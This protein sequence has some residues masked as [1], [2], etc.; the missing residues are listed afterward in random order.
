MLNVGRRRRPTN[1]RYVI[2]GEARQR[3]GKGIQEPQSSVLWL[4]DPL[5]LAFAEARASAPARPG[6]T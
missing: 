5:P 6:V 2:P 3:R 1:A 4:L